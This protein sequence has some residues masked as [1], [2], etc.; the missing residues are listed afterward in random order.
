MM[1]RQLISIN[2]APMRLNINVPLGRFDITS[3]RASWDVNITKSELTVRNDPIKVRIDRRDMYA[4]M[5]IYMP[6]DF[7]R[8]TVDEGRQLML[9]TIGDIVEDWKVIGRSTSTNIVADIAMK[10]SLDRHFGPIELQQIWI[11]GV[12]PNITWEGGSPT[13]VD[14]SPFR[15]DINWQTHVR[16]NIQYHKGNNNIS[17]SQWNQV[18]IEYLGT[19]E[20]ILKIGNESRAKWHMK[21]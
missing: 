2:T 14:F 18:N 10:N 7:A 19:A 17:V 12:R 4:S 3:P 15:M 8:K 20:D 16:P 13:K 11:P 1:V 6:D 5:G 9:E 21:I